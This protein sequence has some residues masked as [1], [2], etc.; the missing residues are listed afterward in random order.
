MVG[1]KPLAL[2]QRYLAFK[3][4]AE[5]KLSVI[6]RYSALLRGPPK[7]GLVVVKNQVLK[8]CPW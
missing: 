8:P 1:K 4:R 2:K 7:C 6:Q 3:D 5:P